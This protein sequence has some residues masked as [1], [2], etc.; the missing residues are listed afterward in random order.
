MRLVE[1]IYQTKLNS[2]QS[3][4]NANELNLENQK[5]NYHEYFALVYKVEQQRILDVQLKLIEYAVKV[6][7]EISKGNN[8]RKVL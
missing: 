1:G 6:L 4:L 5:L 3:P 7:E 8:L 2:F